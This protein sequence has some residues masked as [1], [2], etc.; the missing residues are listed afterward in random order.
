ML[1]GPRRSLRGRRDDEPARV[2]VCHHA[3]RAYPV[4]PLAWCGACVGVRYG[5]AAAAGMEG[6]GTHEAGFEHVRRRWHSA[7]CGAH[8]RRC[9]RCLL[10]TRHPGVVRGCDC[11]EEVVGV[12]G[13]ERCRDGDGR[14]PP[15]FIGNAEVRCLCRAWGDVRGYHRRLHVCIADGPTCRRSCWPCRACSRASLAARFGLVS[16]SSS[17]SS[18]AVGGGRWG[19]AQWYCGTGS[20]PMWMKLSKVATSGRVA[21]AGVPPYARW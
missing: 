13:L 11:V 16:L 1:L 21:N 17:A 20:S 15:V 5:R 6:S 18:G 8:A 7:A 2:V 9:A 4:V 14:K 10:A 12:R 3:V 19:M